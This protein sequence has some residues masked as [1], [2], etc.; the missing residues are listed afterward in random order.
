MDAKRAREILSQGVAG[1]HLDCPKCRAIGVAETV[2]GPEVSALVEAAEKH[3]EWFHRLEEKQ[4]RL[5]VEGQTFETAS[6]NW[7]E[8]TNAFDNGL[9][10]SELEKALAPF[11]ERSEKGEGK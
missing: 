3:V 2:D 7:N 10:F 11:R 5:L 8:A 1:D 4:H 6:K 9:D